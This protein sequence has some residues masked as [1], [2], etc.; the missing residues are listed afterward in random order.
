[1]SL[2]ELKAIAEENHRS[3][4]FVSHTLF[5]N[6]STRVAL[7]AATAPSPQP[8]GMLSAGM[9]E[10]FE[11]SAAKN[12]IPFGAPLFGLTPEIRIQL[13]E[14]LPNNA[15]RLVGPDGVIDREGTLD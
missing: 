12:G 7:R 9:T 5:M 4:R 13:D 15:W 8:P 2:Q 14:D 10:A 11:M 6:M 3:Q 1:M